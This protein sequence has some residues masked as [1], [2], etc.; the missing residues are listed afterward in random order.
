MKLLTLAI[1]IA[2]VPCLHGQEHEVVKIP[3]GRNLIDVMTAAKIYHYP[4]FMMGQSI[5]RDGSTARGRL[6][7][8]ILN[9][10]VEFI[11]AQGDT[12]A[13]AKDQMLNI[14][15]L[16]IDSSTFYYAHGY[17][18]KLK[19]NKEGK[20]GGKEIWVVTKRE[21]IGGY[22]EAMPG[23][24]AIF[25]YTFYH[26][27]GTFSP[28]LVMNENI[29]MTKKTVYYFGDRFNSF[30]PANKKN[31]L[32]LYSGKKRELEDYLKTNAVDFDKREDVEKLF[33]VLQNQ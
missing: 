7:Y 10:E 11:T 2:A 1:A 29:T 6:N 17:I 30:L 16:H 26:L 32:K 4:Q 12:M 14:K 18:Q 22:G 20:L 5:F 13:I 27:F 8:N 19:E 9:E 15:E 21:K 31:L 24:S 23:T 33:D 28:N 3:A 25:S